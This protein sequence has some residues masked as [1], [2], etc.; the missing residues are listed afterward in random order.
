MIE[1]LFK[2]ALESVC[3]MRDY[4]VKV[5]SYVGIK[6]L[7]IGPFTHLTKHLTDLNKCIVL[8]QFQDG[9][10]NH[11][12]GYLNVVFADRKLARGYVNFDT[13]EFTRMD[14]AVHA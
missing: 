6:T 4:Y 7:N 1:P 12:H 2:V 13:V 14:H 5:L 8:R 10:C 11:S 9:C 3:F